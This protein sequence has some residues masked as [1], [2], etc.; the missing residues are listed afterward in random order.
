[1]IGM[2]RDELEK[3]YGDRKFYV[4]QLPY[5]VY[6]FYELTG[7]SEE[8]IEENLD[9]GEWVVL[10]ISNYIIGTNVIAKNIYSFKFEDWFLEIIHKIP[11]N[12]MIKGT[13]EI[14]PKQEHLY[15][16]TLEKLKSLSN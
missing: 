13:K 15:Y 12:T 11:D 4:N 14:N 16:T 10:G 8:R 3:K 7:W 5:S 2:N 9:K 6:T 1:M